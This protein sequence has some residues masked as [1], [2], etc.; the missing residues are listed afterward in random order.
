MLMSSIVIMLLLMLGLMQP[1]LSSAVIHGQIP[2][3]SIQPQNSSSSLSS[4]MVHNTVKGSDNYYNSSS[5]DLTDLTRFNVTNA[6]D[7]KSDRVVI[8]N[9]D[10]SYKSQYVRAK[11]ILDKYG[12]KATF[13]AVCDWIGASDTGENTKM[14]WQDI[15]ELQKE[16]FDIESHTMTHPYLHELSRSELNFELGQ[17]RQCLQDHGLNATIFAY[18]YGDGSNSPKVV[19]QVSKY[20]DL[21]RTDT[22]YPLTFLHCDIWRGHPSNETDCR[23]FLNSANNN[24]GKLTIANRYSING[25]SH[26][27]IE[28]D[29][30]TDSRTCV[31]SC[32][33]YNNSQM[34]DGFI[35][36]VSS[37]DK[38]NNNGSVRA[39]PIIIYHTIVTFPDVS[40][41]DRPV[42]T[43][44]SLFAQEMQYLHDNGY[45]V[46]TMADL[47]YDKTTNYL[48]LK[49]L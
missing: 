35:S 39:I 7:T 22:D 33:Y 47:K 42:D 43:T 1:I 36:A 40:Y 31:G 21:A 20:Y 8:I 19:K 38:F 6:N 27:H 2:F 48:Y 37:Q 30:S 29:Y 18:P 5:N 9:F 3:I 11:P 15:A 26:R 44:I 12:F 4:S 24:K 41:S 45:R 10:D 28:G 23:A 49:G 34:L 25:W 14:T 13:F 16:G 17:S 32:N 46:L